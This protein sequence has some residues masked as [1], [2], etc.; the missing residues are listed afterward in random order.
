MVKIRRENESLSEC[1]AKDY[2]VLKH[3]KR[4]EKTEREKNKGYN[5]S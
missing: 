2:Q 3:P 5:R 4:I 1:M